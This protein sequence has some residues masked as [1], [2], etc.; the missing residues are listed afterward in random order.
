MVDS[1]VVLLDRD[2]VDVDV[3]VGSEVLDDG[4]VTA[5]VDPTRTS[6]CPLGMPGSARIITAVRAWETDP[7][8]Y[9]MIV[10]VV[11]AGVDADVAPPTLKPRLASCWPNVAAR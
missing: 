3:E 9:V 2:T 11:V 4:E 10:S 8:R 5:T 7:G 1:V 6:T